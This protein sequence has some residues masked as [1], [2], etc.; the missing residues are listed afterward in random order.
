MSYDLLI[1][2]GTV[3]DGGGL[4]GFRA[5]LGIDAEGRV[6]APGFIDGPARRNAQVFWDRLGT[7]A[8]W[9]G[10]TSGIMG[11]CGFSLAP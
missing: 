3:V 8:S 7:G 2:G 5:D 6:V 9:H 10:V 11:N 4:P 1:R